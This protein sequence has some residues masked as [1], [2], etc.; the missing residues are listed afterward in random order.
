MKFYGR[1]E[2]V[3]QHVVEAFRH[4]ETLPQAL[5]PIFIQRKDD[6]PCRKWSYTNQ[7]IAA[8]CGTMDA[9]GFRR[10]K[11]TGRT[12]KKGSKAIWILAPC[13]KSLKEK[14]V[15]GEEVERR[16]LY[17]FK[18]IPVFAV[19]PEAPGRYQSESVK[20]GPSGPPRGHP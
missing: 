16:V 7:L 10:W 8:L 19:D 11:E 17:G 20:P 13:V 18:A 3:S 1:A 2:E 14:G 9:R 6:I 4:P 12:I 5:V 15:K